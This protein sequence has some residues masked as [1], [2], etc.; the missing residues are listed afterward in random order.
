MELYGS[1]LIEYREKYGKFDQGAAERTYARYIEGTGIDHLRELNYY[2]RKS[3]HNLKYFTWV[4]QQGKTV[5]EAGG[6]VIAADSWMAP[7]I[8]ALDEQAPSCSGT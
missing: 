8:A 7:R 2:D 1:R 4:E 6:M 5:E 3:L